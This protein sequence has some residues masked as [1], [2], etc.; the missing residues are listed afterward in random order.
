MT[1]NAMSQDSLQSMPYWLAG[2]G[3]R[4]ST[5]PSYEVELAGFHRA[6]ECELQ[7]LLR[8]LPLRPTMKVLDLACGDGFYTRRIADL[9]GR[10][11]SVTGVDV[12]RAFLSCARAEARSQTGEAHLDFLEA[13][14]DAL[15]FPDETFDFVWCAQNLFSL[16]SAHAVLRHVARVLRPGGVLAVLENDTMHQVVLPWPVALELSLRAAELKALWDE[17]PDPEKYYIGRRL[18]AVLAAA[19]LDPIRTVTLAMDRQ[20][21]LGGP[22]RDLLQAY[23]DGVEQRVAPYLDQAGLHELRQLSSPPPR[24]TCSSNR[25]SP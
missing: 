9:L 22:E 25:T 24:S 2:P 23:L 16:P 19:Q 8:S 11:G 4:A 15:P 6:F 14:F 13:S 10:G 5:L 1:I 18:A 7:A 21:P 17:S 3:A 20:A 12:N